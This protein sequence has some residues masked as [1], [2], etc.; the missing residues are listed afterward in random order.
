MRRSSDSIAALAGALA[1]AQPELLNPEKSLTAV[2]ATDRN[3]AARSFRY[4][5]LSSGLEIVRKTLGKH[6]LS[7]VQTTAIDEKARLVRLTTVLA[8]S[9]GE[10]ISSD[11]PVCSLADIAIPHRMGTALTYARRYSLFALVGITGEDDLDSPD[12]KDA[13]G[14]AGGLQVVGSA[15]S[16]NNEGAVAAPAASL[17]E[18]LRTK[19]DLRR[20]PLPPR[21]EAEASAAARERL[22][23]ECNELRTAAEAT[24]WVETAL[25]IKNTLTIADA[26]LVEA[27]F[28]QKLAELG[29]DEDGSVGDHSDSGGTETAGGDPRES[30]AAVCATP[31]TAPET[32]ANIDTATRPDVVQTEPT[33]REQVD[34]SGLALAEPRRRR[35][36]DHLR[37]VARQACL[38]C[39]RKPSDAHHLRFAQPRALGRKVSDEFTV[40][41]CRLHHRAVHHSGDETSWWAE[42]GIEPLGAAE[43]LWKR[44]LRGRRANRADAGE[45]AEP[46]TQ[47]QVTQPSSADGAPA[48]RAQP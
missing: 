47:P 7:V 28:A 30:G 6:E 4:A 22:I 24:A 5:P 23:R 1:K 2:I 17:A 32:G 16:A 21:L 40:P 34:K 43:R 37:L 39:G 12:A 45:T 19:R 11:W 13:Q 33:A 42:A 26:D 9:S 31:S 8:H 38:V 20:Q 48:V 3:G 41:L 15:N 14:S 44:R 27:T 35:D 36:K 18:R 46:Q 29:P 10:W 25:K